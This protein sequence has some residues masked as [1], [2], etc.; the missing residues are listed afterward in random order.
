MRSVR[1]WSRFY[2]DVAL[3]SLLLVGLTEGRLLAIPRPADIHY[4]AYLE[5]LLAWHFGPPPIARD[6]ALYLT[7]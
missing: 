3:I 1:L 7:S 2:F 4:V 6:I 5:R